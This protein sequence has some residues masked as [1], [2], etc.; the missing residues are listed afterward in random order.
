MMNMD[1]NTSIEQ[2]D[3]V[4][5]GDL[6][7]VRSSV[8]AQDL[9][10]DSLLQKVHRQNTML[11]LTRVLVL[12]LCVPLL[13]FAAMKIHGSFSE[14][15][16]NVEQSRTLEVQEQHQMFL[17]LIDEGDRYL[18]Q[19]KWNI[20]VSFYTKALLAYPD[21]PETKYRLALAYT[22]QCVNEGENC[23]EAEQLIA[24][25]LATRP[26]DEDMLKLSA[27]YFYHVGDTASAINA[28]SLVDDL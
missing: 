3:Q 23:A 11:N 12:V 17:L 25:H 1:G 21:H 24:T 13:Y 19:N 16:M 14:E 6:D 27:S 5:E 28:W 15:K 10:L 4:I 22:Y 18:K 20:A 26:T 2:A 7:A 9:T 8:I